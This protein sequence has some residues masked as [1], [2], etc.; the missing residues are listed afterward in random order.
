[1]A[2][3]VLIAIPV[4]V[5]P[6]MAAVWYFLHRYEGMFDDGR[7]F[8]G[9]IAGFFGGLLVTG[10][11]F[12]VFGFQESEFVSIAGVGGAFIF[13]VV[14]YAFFESGAK[15]MILGLSR[16][17]QRRD[18]PYYGAS[19]GLG[20]GAMAALLFVSLNV[21]A[22]ESRGIPYT[23]ENPLP[24][25]LMMLVPLGNVFVHGAT[26]V[27]VGKGSADGRLWRGWIQATILQMP[28]LGMFWL[29]WPSIGRGDVVVLFPAVASIVYGVAL[30]VIMQ[31][32]VL[33][34]VVPPDI[35]NAVLRAKR[36]EQRA[37]MT[38]AAP[39]LADSE[40]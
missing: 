23:L 7:V 24:F 37:K 15:T 5:I 29:F 19:F 36:R 9:L 30:L 8:F 11:E 21:R 34:K 3:P 2:S 40:E 1:M 14:G 38:G 33:D 22:A 39:L 18:T 20:F 27:V 31:R 6:A 13:F 12:M 35:K 32:R 25:I 10:F 28:V 16:F 4:T 17:R 26:G